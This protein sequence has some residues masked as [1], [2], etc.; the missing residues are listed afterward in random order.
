MFNMKGVILTNLIV[1]VINCYLILSLQRIHSDVKIVKEQ[2]STI[3]CVL[4]DAY[5]LST[6]SVTQKLGVVKDKYLQ[7]KNRV[8]L[9][10][11]YGQKQ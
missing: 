2:Y 11:E 7:L 5:T 9:K 10:Y 4:H 8:G 3:V 1:I 6:G